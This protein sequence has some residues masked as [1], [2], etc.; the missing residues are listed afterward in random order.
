MNI[1]YSNE[2]LFEHSREC[3]QIWHQG[4]LWC[5]MSMI[6][7]LE[8]FL[9]LEGGRWRDV[10]NKHQELFVRSRPKWTLVLAH[11]IS[12]ESVCAVV[13]SV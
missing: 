9:L 5:D 12:Q 1:F 8:D 6:V 13:C 10:V 3:R 7:T 2:G 4:T 11:R